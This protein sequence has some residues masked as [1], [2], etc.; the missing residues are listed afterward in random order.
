MCACVRV[1]VRVCECVCVCVRVCMSLRV[2]VCVRCLPVYGIYQFM[3]Y[4]V[5]YVICLSTCEVAA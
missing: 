2:C 5:T 3:Y 1:C 4:I